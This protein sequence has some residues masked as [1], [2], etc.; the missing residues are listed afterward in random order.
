MASQAKC[1]KCRIWFIWTRLRASQMC[2]FR[3][4]E[5]YCPECG[6]MLHQTSQG[7]RGYRKSVKLPVLKPPPAEPAPVG[8]RPKPNQPAGSMGAEVSDVI[9]TLPG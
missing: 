1:V 4:G 8:A 5:I 7:L 3:I 6:D 9:R 2:G